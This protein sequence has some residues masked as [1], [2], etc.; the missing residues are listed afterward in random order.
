VLKAIL[1]FTWMVVE[2]FQHMRSRGG[3][4]ERDAA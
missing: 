3:Q 4:R 1:V 2:G